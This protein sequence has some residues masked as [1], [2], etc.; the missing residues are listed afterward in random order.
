MSALKEREKTGEEN[1]KPTNQT[2]KDLKTP[3]IL[4]LTASSRG[5]ELPINISTLGKA[6]IKPS[7]LKA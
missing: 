3:Q 4:A 2:K 6:I 7:V 1:Q 5:S